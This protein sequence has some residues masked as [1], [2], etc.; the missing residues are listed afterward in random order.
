MVL[1]P[2]LD[3]TCS[4]ANPKILYRIFFIEIISNLSGDLF[5]NL[6]SSHYLKCLSYLE[7][8]C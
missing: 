1:A 8:K 6:G 5:S 4:S 7:R 3:G 2:Q